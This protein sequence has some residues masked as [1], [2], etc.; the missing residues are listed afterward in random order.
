[1]YAPLEVTLLGQRD[2]AAAA[3]GWE[4]Q[5]EVWNLASFLDL[6]WLAFDWVL[7][8]DGDNDGVVAVGVVVLAVPGTRPSSSTIASFI[9][10]AS[11]LSLGG[12]AYMYVT[13]NARDKADG[14]LV[15]A[16][17]FKLAGSASPSGPDHALVGGSVSVGSVGSQP[18]LAVRESDG[19]EIKVSAAD[20]VVISFSRSHGCISMLKID[21]DV[22]IASSFDGPSHHLWRA[23]TDNDEA[24][25][26]VGIPKWLAKIVKKYPNPLWSY[27]ERWR[28]AGLDRLQSHTTSA[29]DLLSDDGGKFEFVVKSE[30]KPE[31][32]DSVRAMATTSYTVDRDGSV[33]IDVEIDC[34]DVAVPT[35]A[36]V[37]MRMRL[38]AGMRSIK[39]F[40]RGPHEN[41]P[42]RKASAHFGVHESSVAA[43][44]VPY[45]L[46]TTLVYNSVA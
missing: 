10:P 42:D 36:R 40:G 24:G 11:S 38:A 35:L 19:N 32:S 5:V 21:D 31:G 8:D 2:S 46:R 1:M 33:R 16:T 14:R 25:L 20:G 3:G 29:I 37:G 13:V 44:V 27:A 17:Q 12:Q 4:F 6:S 34:S 28:Y 41:Y 9:V 23:P 15:K 39:F 45:L 43:Q 22:I 7:I 18:Q 30:L 26:N